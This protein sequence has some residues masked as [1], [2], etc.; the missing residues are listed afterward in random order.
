MEEYIQFISNLKNFTSVKK[1]KITSETTNTDVVEFLASVQLSK[2]TKIREYLE[3][4]IDIKKLEDQTKYLF[5]LDFNIF[6]KELKSSKLKKIILDLLPQTMDKAYKD[7][8]LESY[9]VYLIE[10]YFKLKDISICYHQ[11]L[12]PTRKKQLKKIIKG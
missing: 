9:Y 2:N 3:K 5:D 8:F 4:I 10:R 11:I 7:A 12:Y 6:F 1:M